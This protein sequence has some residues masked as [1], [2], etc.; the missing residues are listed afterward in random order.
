MALNNLVFIVFFIVPIS[1][2]GQEEIRM[3][4]F[5]DGGDGCG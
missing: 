1:L 2:L 5:F 4:I 3:S